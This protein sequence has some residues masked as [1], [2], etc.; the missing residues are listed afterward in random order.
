[1]RCGYELPTRRELTGDGT[2]PGLAGPGPL[3]LHSPRR[4]SATEISYRREKAPR[5]FKAKDGSTALSGGRSP[6]GSILPETA[7]TLLQA[8]A[9]QASEIPP[10]AIPALVGGL[11]QIKAFLLIRGTRDL[12]EP[13][14]VE[15]SVEADRF[16]SAREAAAIANVPVKFLYRRAR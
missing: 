9:V 6:G 12:A 2:R 15:L 5:A 16:L 7:S 14:P 10:E 1:M 8:L 11:E 4:P 13:R 3:V